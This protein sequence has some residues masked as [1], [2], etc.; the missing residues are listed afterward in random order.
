MATQVGG[1][2]HRYTRAAWL[3]SSQAWMVFIRAGRLPLPSARS[4]PGGV[5]PEPILLVSA[6]PIMRCAGEQVPFCVTFDSD[7]LFS[8]DK[9]DRFR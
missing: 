7:G 2:N 5:T 3:H 1:L 9:G 6:F 4:I 8:S